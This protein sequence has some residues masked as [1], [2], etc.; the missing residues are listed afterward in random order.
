MQ[1]LNIDW[2]KIFVQLLAGSRRIFLNLAHCHVG[3]FD[4]RRDK[5]GVLDRYNAVGRHARLRIF[6]VAVGYRNPAACCDL[7]LIFIRRRGCNGRDKRFEDAGDGP[8]GLAGGRTE[9][10]DVQ[11]DTVLEG[12]KRLQGNLFPN[13]M[14]YNNP[15]LESSL[16]MANIVQNMLIQSWTDPAAKESGPIRIF[17]A[18]PLAWEDVEFRDLRTEGAFLVS[19]KR[20]NGQTQWVRIKSLAGEPCRVRPGLGGEVRVKSNRG[21][22][23]RQVSPGLYEIDMK[24]GDTVRLY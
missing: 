11:G 7:Q 9:D 16:G 15:C 14:W 20:T 2:Q 12:L 24:K 8:V 23:L 6:S 10:V 1:F 19:A 13:G 3:Q 22:E 17:P 5:R 4:D 18:T 21:I